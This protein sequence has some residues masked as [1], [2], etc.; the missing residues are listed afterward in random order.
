[1][2]RE[3]INHVVLDLESTSLNPN[4]CILSIALVPVPRTE[5]IDWELVESGMSFYCIV[6]VESCI[7]AGFE[8]SAQNFYWWLSRNEEARNHLIEGLRKPI[9]TTLRKLK[10][11]LYSFD[12]PYIW[13]HKDFDAAVLRTYYRKLEIPTPFRKEQMMDLRTLNLLSDQEIDIERNSPKHIAINDALHEAKIV[14][15]ELDI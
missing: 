6:D 7:D 12:S 3:N 5:N 10:D 9:K 1:M 15:E 2:N 13:S 8:M 14:K 11:Y 4:C